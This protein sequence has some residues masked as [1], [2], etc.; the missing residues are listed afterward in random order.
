MAKSTGKTH[1]A[2]TAPSSSSAASP[3][4][5]RVRLDPARGRLARTGE[6]RPRHTLS[7]TPYNCGCLRMFAQQ[8][9]LSVNA[10][11][12][13]VLERAFNLPSFQRE[14]AQAARGDAAGE[15]SG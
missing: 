4:R 9:G 6:K 7:L 1:T 14:F 12:N 8:R 2:S 13:V 10:A 5:G 15:G 11:L 3:A